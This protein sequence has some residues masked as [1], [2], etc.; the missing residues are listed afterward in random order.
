MFEQL[1]AELDA[2]GN[3]GDFAGG[4]VEDAEFGV[5]Q[6]TAELRDEE[7]FAVGGVEEAVG[8]AFVRR[9]DVDGD[10]GVHG[11][12]AVA[13]EGSEAVDEV[14]GLGGQTG[15]GPSGVGWVS[16]PLR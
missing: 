10:A 6:E 1:D 15:E 2:A 13:G 16:S 7:K 12:I 5:E 8:H 3:E 9:V 4:E 11:E 14:C